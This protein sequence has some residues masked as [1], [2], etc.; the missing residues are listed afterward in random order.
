MQDNA[1]RVPMPL[2][3]SADT[4]AQGNPIF[5]ACSLDRAAVHSEHHTVALGQRDHLDARLHARSLFSQH[6]FAAF[7]VFDRLRQENR[8][9][10][11]EDMLP[12]QVL[13][14]T[15]VITGAVLQ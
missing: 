14:Q 8:N 13:M 7:E 9:L 5:A 10:Q 15:V 1:Q 2:P 12:V 6:K 3:Q 4:V 11:R